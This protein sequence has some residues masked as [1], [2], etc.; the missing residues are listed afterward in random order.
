VVKC[1][2]GDSIYR[3]AAA[4]KDPLSE[5]L[6]ISRTAS[7]L[8]LDSCVIK[9]TLPGPFTM[10]RQAKNEFY[11]TRKSCSW[12]TPRHQRRAAR[13]EAAEA[14][15]SSSTSRGFRPAPTRHGTWH[16]RQ[17]TA[18]STAPRA[19]GPALLL[20]IRL[21]R[22]RQ[23]EPLRIS[24]GAPR[25]EGRADLDRSGQPISISRTSAASATRP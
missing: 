18:P 22:P 17:S 13:S 8:P 5:L 3:T 19:S 21:C 24:A 14:T 15:V 23:A 2:S 12:I 10:S 4:G 20:R 7:A 6:I 16:C 1:C 25:F 9:I 11:K